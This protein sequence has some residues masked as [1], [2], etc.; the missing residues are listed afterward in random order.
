VVSIF[1]IVLGHRTMAVMAYR[2]G[3]FV[4]QNLL[5]IDAWTHILTWV[6][7]VMPIFFIVG[8]FTNAHSWRSTSER[9]GDAVEE[10]A[11]R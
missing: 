7:Q 5:E 1:V 11:A 9:G 3:R 2:D 10:P 8:G 4:G 6:F